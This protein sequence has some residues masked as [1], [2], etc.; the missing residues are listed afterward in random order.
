MLMV[1]TVSLFL[2]SASPALLLD[3]FALYP[4]QALIAHPSPHAC[5]IFLPG[6]STFIFFRRPRGWLYWIAKQIIF[7]TCCIFG[8]LQRIELNHGAP[9]ARL[10]T[11][12]PVIIFSH[13]LGGNRAVYS[14]ICSE[15]A[16]HGYVVLAIEHA[17]GTASCCKLAGDK[18]W[19]FYKGL[20]G[21]EGQVEK[22]R[23]R[24]MEMKTAVKVLRALHKGEN[25]LGLKLSMVENPAGFLAGALDLRCLAAVGHSYGGATTAALV[26][27]D[28]LFR[29]GVCLDP[30]W[31]ALPEE[32]TCLATWRTKAPLLVMGSH[33]WNV[34]NMQGQ[35]LCGPERQD[36]IFNAV[37]VRKDHGQR[38]GA[39]AMLLVIA[40]SSHNTFAD[41]L[42]LFSE[43]VGWALRA[44]GLTARLDPLLG[45]HLVNASVLNFLSLHLPLTGDQRQ[46]QTWAP[47]SG[48]TA[49]DRIA[50]LDKANNAPAA[51]GRG[52][53]LLSWLFPGRGLLNAISDA[54]LNRV[55][56]VSKYSEEKK[57]KKKNRGALELNGKAIEKTIINSDNGGEE[58]EENNKL[59]Q[60]GSMPPDDLV[61]GEEVLESALPSADPASGPHPH[62]PSRPPVGFGEEEAVLP[63]GGSTIYRYDT[64]QR[65]AL[66]SQVGS[67]YADVVRAEHADQFLALLGEEHVWKCEVYS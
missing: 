45:I 43:H 24:I 27:E 58:V 35:M 50:E 2:F 15:L 67:S 17:D 39:G 19:R 6:L 44:L 51:R 14:I 48:H 32:A 37:K 1:R 40:G 53:G 46:L 62:A 56:S 55:I 61:T 57:M 41:P 12:L 36:K 49:L 3:T 9:L 30:W 31:A 28:P 38:N 52:V 13:G 4:L 26:S 22:T 65:Q 8:R 47:S 20:G 25:L 34:P 21:D 11:R 5:N 16:S 10:P 63:A 7:I 18:G 23:H 33:D 66:R 54:M 42:A 64:G 29:C 60:Q 59:E